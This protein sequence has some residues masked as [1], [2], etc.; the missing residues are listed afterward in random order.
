MDAS[1]NIPPPAPPAYMQCV[2][3]SVE[4]Y[5]NFGVNRLIM[6]SLLKTEGGTVGSHTK[7]KNG[8]E[9]L[10][11]WQINSSWVQKLHGGERMRYKLMHD[12]CYNADFAAWIVANELRKYATGNSTDKWWKLLANYNSATPRHN[13]IYQNRL[14]ASMRWVY[15]KTSFRYL[16]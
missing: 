13:L 4:K 11:P 14:Y 12:V 2:D 10:G 6:Y 8:T 5:S 7:N 16:A 15:E 1:T 3:R 9:D